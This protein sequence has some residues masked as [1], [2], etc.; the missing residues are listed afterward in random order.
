MREKCPVCGNDTLE[1]NIREEDVQYFGRM[2]I[3]STF[4]TSCG[5]RHNDVILVDQKDPV[6]ITFV[7]SGEEDLKV[8]VI[9]SSYA[10]IRIPEIGVSIDPVTSGE[11]F[12]SNVEGLLFR[13]IN[14]MSQ[15]LRDS[16]ENREEILERLKMI[17]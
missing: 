17:G 14:I 12:V 15:L 2:L 16:P 7:A 8:R 5:Y 10:S 11:S 9:R 13:V 3:M 1:T 4:C 6:K